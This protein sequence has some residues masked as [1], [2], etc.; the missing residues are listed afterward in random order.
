MNN[1][2]PGEIFI[3]DDN[4]AEHID[5]VIDG[6]L[7]SKGC[8]PRDFSTHPV[9][10]S[11]SMK[12][13][14]ELKLIPRSEWKDRIRAM[15]ANRS[16]LS[17]IRMCGNNGQII[18]SLDQNGKGYCWAHSSTA[19]VM[20]VRAVNGEPYVPLSAYAVACMEKNFRDEG[21][22]G[23]ESLEFISTRGVPSSQFW[24]MQSMNRANDNPLTW[25]NAAKHKTT[26]GW[27]D[28]DIPQYEQKLTFDQVMTL[29]FCRIPVVADLSWWGHSVLFLD[30]VE[31]DGQWGVRFLNSWGDDYGYKGM[32]IL[33]GS[34][35]IPDSAV[36]P[37]VVV[38]SLV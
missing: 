33:L 34:R 11:S 10:Y 27:W 26:F 12:A 18:P 29:L 7:K 17:D 32:S 38:P 24:P 19:A 13:L 35:A 1:F 28:L 15:E 9:G 37:G 31:K 16:R 30:P 20:M 2:Y 3:T 21:G 36:A 4:F 23:A 22:W 25:E 5:T 8:K 14:P 6:E